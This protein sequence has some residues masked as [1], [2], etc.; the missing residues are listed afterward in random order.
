MTLWGPRG[1]QHA[2]LPCPSSS[3]RVCSTW[4]PSSQWCH[5]TISFSWPLLLLPS[6]FASIRLFSSE[7]ALHNRFSKYWS[8]N[9]SISPSNEYSG[10]M[11][12]GL[13]DSIFLLSKVLSR[14]FS[15]ATVQSH[16][17]F[18]SQP[19]SY[20]SLL[21]SIH[22][23]WKNHSFDY[24]DLCCQ[25]NVCFLICYLGCHSFPSKEQVP[26]N[27]M[28]AVSICSDF[29]AQE[30]KVCHCFPIYLP[31]RDGTKCHEL[32]LLKILLL[33]WLF[34]FTLQYCIGFTIHQHASTMVYTCSA[35][36]P[37]VSSLCTSPKLPVSCIEPGLEIRFLYYTC[38]NAI[39]PNHPPLPLPQSPKDCS[40]HLCLF[41]YLTYRVIVTIFLNSIYMC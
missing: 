40:I 2:R 41:C 6:I 38:F 12:L 8:F 39:L 26:F 21:T 31:W 5:P 13:T 30:N 24:M 19:F 27:F 37:S 22:D 16:Q 4:C 18:G 33:L 14:V 20:Y 23:Y 15:N 11:Y 17:F 9:F 34:L 29:G 32:N 25:S 28:A 3:P 36:H 7:S 1:L 10:L 35:S